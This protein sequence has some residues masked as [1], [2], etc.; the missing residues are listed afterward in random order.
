MR[1]EASRLSVRYGAVDGLRDVDIVVE[2]GSITTVIGANGA[3]KSTLLNAFAGLVP[4]AAGRILLGGRDITAV[5]AE[6]RAGLG[7]ALSPE[8]RRLFA[9]MTVHENLLVG[10]YSRGRGDGV[11]RDL[12]RIYETFENLAR[13]RNSLA[14]NLSGGEQQMCAVGRALMAQ[15]SVLL[16]DEPTLGLAP[17]VVA[18]FA[19]II[20][21]IHKSGVTIVL[22]EQNSRL[23]LSLAD[24]A[25]VLESGRVAL[26]GSARSLLSDVRI[27]RSYLGA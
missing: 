17:I 23:A 24:Q 3:G 9:D 12:D 21:K 18:D 1:L 14:R 8:G 13:R 7:I 4:V 5:A 10:A 11:A 27:Q 6:E 25:Y 26:S 22:V 19:R 2:A 16:L 20:R 15:P